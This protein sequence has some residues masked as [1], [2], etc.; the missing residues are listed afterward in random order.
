MVGFCECGGKPVGSIK[1]GSFLSSR[2]AVLYHEIDVRES[3]VGCW[4]TEHD[5]TVLW[6]V[7]FI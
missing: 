4:N 1:A 3:T 2:V 5:C 7:C 6:I